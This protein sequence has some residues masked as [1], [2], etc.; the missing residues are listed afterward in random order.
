[1]TKHAYICINISKISC[2]ETQLARKC[3]LSVKKKRSYSE[4]F[5]SIYLLSV[6]VFCQ[7]THV[8]FYL[9]NKS[10]H[11][12]LATYQS[13]CLV[14]VCTK[15]HFRVPFFYMWQRFCISRV[16]WQY[17]RE[18]TENLRDTNLVILCCTSII[19]HNLSR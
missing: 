5:F 11:E 3:H 13:N 8:P 18:N 4:H 10:F 16:Y 7:F 15:W 1:M 19:V 6:F 17:F 2:F 14:I 12:T 9:L